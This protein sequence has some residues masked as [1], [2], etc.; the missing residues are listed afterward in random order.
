MINALRKTNSQI[1]RG[2]ARQFAPALAARK[3]QG[4]EIDFD[5]GAP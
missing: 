2:Q 5:F 3:A 4:H 1:L